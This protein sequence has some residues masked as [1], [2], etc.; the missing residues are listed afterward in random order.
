MKAEVRTSRS[1]VLL[2]VGGFALSVTLSAAVTLLL[3]PVVISHSGPEIWAG[4]AVGQAVGTAFAV[5]I[6]FGWGATGPTQVARAAPIDRVGI[7][8][9]SVRGRLVL[10]LPGV[11]IAFLAAQSISAL[12][13]PAVGLT[14]ASF[15][16][17][18]LLAGWYFTGEGRPF[19][20]LLYDT[21]P[22]V[23]GSTLGAAALLVG[24][25]VVVLPILQMAGVIT[26][27]VLSVAVAA[28]GHRRTSM[29]PAVWSLL[30]GQSHGIVITGVSALYISV[31]ITLVALI[32]PSGLPAYALADKL[33]R[34]ATT[35]F[36]PI[37]QYLQGWVPRPGPSSLDR[38]VRMAIASTAAVSLGAGAIFAVSLPA[39]GDLLSHGTI[40]LGWELSVAFAALLVLIVMAQAVGLV[41][42]IALDRTR[43]YSRIVA[44]GAL[45]GI[46][47]VAVGAYI[48]GALG[49]GTAM[50][51]V[52]LLALAV[53]LVRLL[54]VLGYRRK[55]MIDQS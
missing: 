21:V 6:G 53:E 15:A 25:D 1:S 55:L 9:D 49:A 31:P 22:R 38:R 2:S 32:A 47:A 23:V 37:I 48:G 50:G 28:R 35:A 16:L 27:L 42:L 10:A 3:V 30:R 24:M 19:S 41:G 13:T 44:A 4:L 11:I 14:A 46:P 26:A 52:E 29:A 51:C 8:I 39:V 40:R 20:L 7:L 17:T 33:L 18:G 43:D 34:F 54:H 36:G 12:S 45:L 5:L